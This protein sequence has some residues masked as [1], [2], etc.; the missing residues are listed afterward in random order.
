MSVGR[1][2]RQAD[3]LR[4][5][6]HARLTCRV[7]AGTRDAWM[8]AADRP[9]PPASPPALSSTTTPSTWNSSAVIVPV[10]SKHATSTRPASVM[11]QGSVQK[12]PTRMSAAT[13]ALTASESSMGSSGGTTDVMIMMQWRSSFQRLR[14]GSPQ[15]WYMTYE[16]DATAKTRSPRMKKKASRL[17]EVTRSVDRM[18]VRMSSPCKMPR[19]GEGGC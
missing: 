10:L 14:R 18:I 3:P 15:P 1:G 16:L 11:R 6:C 12:T 5:R 17:P 19:E 7:A 4:S 13:L 2:P 8:R 9:S